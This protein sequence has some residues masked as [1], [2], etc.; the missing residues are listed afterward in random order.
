MI[1]YRIVYLQPGTH[2]DEIGIIPSFLDEDD[3]RPAREQ[4]DANYQHGGGWR[5]LPNF[6]LDGTTLKYPGD[7]PMQPIAAM[8]LRNEMVLIYPSAFVMVLQKHGTFEVAR[9]D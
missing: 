8:Q 3:P 5:S 6:D 2:P 9:M 1:A 7:P 4:L